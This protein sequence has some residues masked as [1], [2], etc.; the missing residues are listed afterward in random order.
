MGG[1][2]A[3]GQLRSFVFDKTYYATHPD[4]VAG[5][6][7][8]RLRE[9]YLID[10]LFRPGCIHLNY[11][12]Q[13]RLVIGGVTPLDEAIALPAQSHPPSAAGKPFLE[14]RELG[15]VNIGGPGRVMVDGTAYSLGEYDALY[16]TLGAAD[17]AFA[18]DDLARPALFYLASTPAHRA[19]E[20][21]LLPLHANEP[22]RRGQ[23]DTANDRRIYQFIHP[24][25]CASAQLM[26]GLT[27][28]SPG[29]V[30]NT[31][32][33]HR[34]QRRSEV[35]FYFGLAP[36]DRL[37]HVMGTPEDTRHIIVRNEEAVI[38]P[39]WSLHMGAGTAKYAFIWAMGGENLDY[40]DMDHVDLDD[41][42]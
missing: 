18:S 5:A 11:V 14:R 31:M 15:I 19:F 1:K 21:R 6:S 37:F 12:H 32:P 25:V 29:S 30:W 34:H 13:E 38:C 8:R 42:I 24:G 2:Q 16:V 4:M 23:A 9:L 3:N 35:Y 7:N 33:P 40:T 41:L 39:S 22:M 28:L 27:M 36:K 10:D 20:T 26:M 17:I